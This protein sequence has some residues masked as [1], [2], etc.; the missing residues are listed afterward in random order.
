MLEKDTLRKLI[1]KAHLVIAI[2]VILGLL[3]RFKEATW[4][5]VDVGI[6]VVFDFDSDPDSFRNI[7]LKVGI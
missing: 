3:F 5:I 7:F 1:G 2:V 6:I 4:T